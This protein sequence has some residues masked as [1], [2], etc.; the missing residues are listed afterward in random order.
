VEAN[1]AAVYGGGIYCLTTSAPAISGC[2]FVD[3]SAGFGGAITCVDASEPSITSCTLAGN[4]APAGAGVY[5]WNSW[6]TV[7]SA[8]IAFNAIGRAIR[9]EGAAA[10]SLDCCDLFGNDGGDWVGC[11]ADQLGSNGNISLDPLFCDAAGG[12][13]TLQ[14]LSPCSPELSPGAC[15]LI[16]ALPVTCGFPAAIADRNPVGARRRSLQCHPN[17]FNGSTTITAALTGEVS[18]TLHIHDVSGRLV[19][20]LTLEQKGVGDLDVE[21]DGRDAQGRRVGSGVYYCEVQ[22]G[23]SVPTRTVILAR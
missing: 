1:T 10:V 16:G 12:D 19:R 11:I 7:V 8:I 20:V 14:A 15:G 22:T 3:N 6:P 17:P 18:V 2:T 13:L 5:S 9:C 21:W 4:S 23:S